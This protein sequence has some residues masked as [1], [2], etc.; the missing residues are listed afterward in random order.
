MKKTYFFSDVHFGL[1]ERHIEEAK[2]NLMLRLLGEVGQEG[3]RLYM[4]GDILD[5]W[6]EYKHV[7]P[8]GH[9]QFFAAL[10]DLVQSGVEVHY[11]AGNHDFYLGKYFDEEIGIKTH[12]GAVLHD[13]DGKRF[14]ILHGDGVGRGDTGYKIFRAVVRNDFNLSWFR[15]LHPDFGVGLMA[16][17]SKLSRKHSYTEKDDGENERLIVFANEE[18]S[19]IPFDYFVCGHRHI[20][21]LHQ[22][23]N[24][25][26]YY[27]NCGTWIGGTPTYAVFDG[28]EMRLM[29]AKTQEVLFSESQQVET[30][31][32]SL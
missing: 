8:K 13:I 16:F 30:L 20:V 15:W 23:R 11:I 10:Y 22:L 12:Y 19:R 6:M 2:M 1:Q 26:S 14:Y 24:Q 9:F 21:K 32:E 17:L 18:L 4:V 28:I 29:K 3:K 31:T 5:Y 7:V 27:V 25:K